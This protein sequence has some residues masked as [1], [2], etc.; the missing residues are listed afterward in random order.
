[1]ARDKGLEDLL[2]DGLARVPG[3]TQKAMFGGWAW[4][5]N[6]NLL[7]GARKGGLLLRVGKENEEWVLEIAGVVPMMMRERRMHGWVRA[8]PEVYGNDKLREKLLKA[9]LEFTRSLPGK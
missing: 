4:L 8:A 7:C 1:M 6:G 5:L 3:L 9:A 2:A